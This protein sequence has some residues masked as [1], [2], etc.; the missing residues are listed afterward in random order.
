MVDCADLIDLIYE[1]AVVP[2]HWTS[3]LDGMAVIAEGEGTMLFATRPDATQWTCS[4]AIREVTETWIKSRWLADNGRGRRLV[5]IRE[6]RFLTDLDA[7]TLEELDR[8][9]FYTDFLRPRGLGWCVGTTINSP[10]EDTLVFSIER[11]YHKGPVDRRKV[12]LLDT[13][14]PHLARSALLSARIGLERARATADALE[15]I[16]FPAVVMSGSG[17]AVATNTGFAGCAPAIYIGALDEV[18]FCDPGLQ[19]IFA[20]GL[21]AMRTSSRTR[22]GNSIPVRAGGDTPAMVAHLLPLRRSAA[23]M[24]FSASAVLFVTLPGR[25]SGPQPGLLEALFDL[26][27]AEAKVASLVVEGRSV[28]EIARSQGVQENSVRVQLKS[29]FG[30]TGVHRQA[31]LVSLFG[32]PSYGASR[33]T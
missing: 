10:S 9:P 14:R 17:R 2:E 32:F 29:I 28:A 4:P 16:G 12:P 30:K 8:E 5:P 3:V 22:L 26:T 20:E 15:L 6:P 1:A 27:P 19:A 18:K 23:D 13:L 25:R 24:F 31:E 21:A 11:A 7:F 33:S